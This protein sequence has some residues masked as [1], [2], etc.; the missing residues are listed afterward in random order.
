MLLD[1]IQLFVRVVANRNLAKA[2]REMHVS[3]SSVTQRLKAL[4]RDFGVKLYSAHR[5]GIELTPAGETLLATASEVLH[6]I[7]SLQQV[8]KATAEESVRNDEQ[9]KILTVAATYNPSAKYLPVAIA[10]FK[11]RQPNVEVTFV[12]SIRSRVEQC[13]R[14]GESEI[15]LIQSPSN[16]C[17]SALHVEHF[18]DDVLC[19]FTYAGHPLTRPRNLTISALSKSA[20]I[21]RAGKG[22]TQKALGLLRARG[23]KPNIV[24]RCATPHAVKAAVLNKMG[25]GILFR[26]MLD[27]EVRRRKFK[28]L[29]IAGLPPLTGST[30]IVFQRT[31]PLSA[32][33][34]EFLAIL[35][36]LKL[37]QKRPVELREPT[38]TESA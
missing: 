24:L 5:A 31:K 14:D 11:K 2:A 27:E 28:L 29:R 1:R 38:D 21:V 36:A 30:Y 34:A 8:I 19:F 3:P 23:I 25:V 32:P 33:A 16:E 26:N 15:A 12:S 4:E 10:T 22:T 9:A 18:A 20:L 6:R 37:K 13:L 17:R 35:R 7:E